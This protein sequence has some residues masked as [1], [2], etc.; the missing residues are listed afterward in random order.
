MT[1]LKRVDLNKKYTTR[2]GREVVS[3]HRIVGLTGTYGTMPIVAAVALPYGGEVKPVFYTPEGKYNINNE[4]SELDLIEPVKTEYVFNAEVSVELRGMVTITAW[5]EDD[6][7]QELEEI[8]ENEYDR[9]G[10]DLEE[11]YADVELVLESINTK[12]V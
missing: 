4:E 1:N 7:R 6:A 8:L 9:A 2:D 10:V 11:E 5:N 3:L 12:D